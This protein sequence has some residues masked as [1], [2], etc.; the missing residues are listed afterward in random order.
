VLASA[1]ENQPVLFVLAVITTFFTAFYI[2]RVVFL[3]FFGEYRGDHKPHESSKMM[4]VPMLFLAVP[5]VASGWLNANAGFELLFEEGGATQGFWHGIFGLLA[6]P[7]AWI[8]LLAAG[9]GIFTAYSLYIKKWISPEKIKN[10]F[11]A[12]YVIFSRKYWM[13]DLYET[14]IANNLLYRG[15]FRAFQWFDR[16]VID[17]AA[18]GVA[19]ITAGTGRMVRKLQNGQLQMYGLFAAAGIIIIVVLALFRG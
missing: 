10:N 16:V 19:Y 9:L 14:L 2:F 17:G 5:A 15:A 8:S 6:H 4:L 18:N 7:L 11:H 13:D 12:L 3:V 1:F